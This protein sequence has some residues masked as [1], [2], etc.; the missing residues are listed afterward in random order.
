MKNY[1]TKQKELIFKVLFENTDKVLTINDIKKIIDQKKLNIGLTTIYR[2]LFELEKKILV[3][4]NIKDNG[5]AEYQ[6]LKDDCKNFFHI[7]CTKC[8]K[9]S[10]LNCNEMESVAQHIQKEHG[11]YINSTTTINGSCSECHD[12]EEK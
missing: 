7:K 8:G 6:L 4:K 5:E 11:F 1:K 9:I 2:N 10:H 12:E 3:I